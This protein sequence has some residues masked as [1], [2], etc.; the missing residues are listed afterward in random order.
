MPMRRLVLWD[1]D[2][3]LVQFGDVGR[4]M[5]RDAIEVVTGTPPDDAALATISFAGRT[6]LEIA[7]ELLEISGVADGERHLT[8]LVEAL[9]TALASRAATLP[10]RGRALPG[11]REAL[12][13][14]HGLPGTVQSVLTGNV[15]A[16][17]A[18]KLAAF[19]LDRFVDLEVGGYGSDHRERPRLVGVARARAAAKYGGTFP[20]EDTVLIGDSPL[21]VAAARVAGAACVAV[22]TGWATVEELA[23]AGAETVVPDLTATDGIISAILG[24]APEPRV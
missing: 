21:D 18:V 19:D 20:P 1:L 15:A 14:L 8:A 17:A 5:F 16:N 2:G 22:A 4:E 13:A 24:K 9:A 7:L 11:A 3:T 23:A 6:D 12:S 10:V